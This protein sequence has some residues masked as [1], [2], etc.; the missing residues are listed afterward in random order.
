LPISVRIVVTLTQVDHAWIGILGCPICVT[1]CTVCVPTNQKG[2]S[3]SPICNQC[4]VAITINLGPQSRGL[5]VLIIT[6]IIACWGPEAVSSAHI[7]Y[8]NILYQNPLP[9]DIAKLV[10]TTVTVLGKILKLV[11]LN[12]LSHPS[13]LPMVIRVLKKPVL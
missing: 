13:V 8:K 10:Y 4:I 3:R 12:K 1:K 2:T 6:V 7:L 9:Q 11:P 5:S